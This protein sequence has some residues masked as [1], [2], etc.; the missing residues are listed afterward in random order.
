VKRVEEAIVRW[1][2]FDEYT[3]GG[4]NLARG[5][6]PLKEFSEYVGVTVV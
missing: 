3:T 6:L 4:R 2:F 1:R 5:R